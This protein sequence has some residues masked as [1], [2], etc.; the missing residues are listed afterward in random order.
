[1]RTPE[2]RDAVF[3]FAIVE[4]GLLPTLAFS[5]PHRDPYGAGRGRIAVDGSASIGLAASSGWTHPGRP[6]TV[7]TRTGNAVSGVTRIE[8]SN[9]SRSAKNPYTVRRLGTRELAM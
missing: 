4:L 8:G 9:P 2:R 7:L 1:M 6:R 5:D 3:P